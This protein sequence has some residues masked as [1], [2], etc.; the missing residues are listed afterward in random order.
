MYRTIHLGT[1]LKLSGNNKKTYARQTA[2]TN[3]DK[4]T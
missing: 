1:K 3:R 4:E 2:Q